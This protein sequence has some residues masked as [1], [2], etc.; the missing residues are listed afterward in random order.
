[1]PSELTEERDSSL[2]RSVLLQAG[3]AGDALDRIRRVDDPEAVEVTIRAA[4][5]CTFGGI[6][7]KL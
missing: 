2:S 3:Q 1:M 7:D 6:F 4:A 5:A